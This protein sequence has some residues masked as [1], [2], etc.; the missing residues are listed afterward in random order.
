MGW[1]GGEG[2]MTEKEK[3]DE[4]VGGEEGREGGR[5]EEKGKEDDDNN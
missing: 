2:Q 4:R 5:Q 3:R 1:G